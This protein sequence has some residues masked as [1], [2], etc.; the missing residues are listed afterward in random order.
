MAIAAAKM[1]AR[2]VTLMGGMAVA[3]RQWGWQWWWTVARAVATVV[4][5]EVVVSVARALTRAVVRAVV[6]GSLFLTNY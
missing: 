3:H 4:T 6:G 2:A 1:V 5:V